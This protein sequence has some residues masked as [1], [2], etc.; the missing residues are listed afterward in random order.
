MVDLARQ[1]G[2]KGGMMIYECACGT[3]FTELDQTKWEYENGRCPSCWSEDIKEVEI[4]EKEE[5]CQPI[6]TN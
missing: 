6:S 1:R 5:Q 3:K 2:I 4:E